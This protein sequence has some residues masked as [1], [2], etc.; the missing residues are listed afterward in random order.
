MTDSTLTEFYI[1][2]LENATTAAEFDS[3]PIGA[4]LNFGLSAENVDTV[5]SSDEQRIRKALTAEWVAS[6]ANFRVKAARASNCDEKRGSL[7]VVGTGI[8]AMRHVTPEAR[9]AIEL[10]DKVLH[11][12]SDPL[13]PVWLERISKSVDSLNSIY[14]PGKKRERIYREIVDRLVAEVRSGSRICLVMYGHPGFYMFV[15]HHAIRELRL[16]GF[17]ASMLPG[18]SAEDCLIADL[19]VDPGP[20]GCQGF[21]ADDFLLYRRRFDSGSALILWQIGIV[22]RPEIPPRQPDLEVMAMVKG[23]LLEEYP[24]SH[25]GIIYE[26]ASIPGCQ[27]RRSEVSISELHRVDLTP[28]STLYI[29]PLP[30]RNPDPEILS[31]LPAPPRLDRH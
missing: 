26:A 8:R 28:I 18:I 6:S 27:F 14:T 13:T 19:G 12:A 2:L 11:L 7:T 1:S 3:D 29:P 24:A 16:Q 15:G 25:R 17:E 21:E 30:S 22:G 9:I 31:K 23:R 20:Y 4:C 5:L 10:A